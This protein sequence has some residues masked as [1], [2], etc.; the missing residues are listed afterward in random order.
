[1]FL[2]ILWKVIIVEILSPQKLYEALISAY[3]N[4]T[5][6]PNVEA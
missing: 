1:M 6:M 3:V 2:L 5:Q 4:I